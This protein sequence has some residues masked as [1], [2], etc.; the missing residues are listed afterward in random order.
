[1]RR[2]T[3]RA[4]P[5]GRAILQAMGALAVALLL[6]T[7]GPSPSAPPPPAPPAS[8]PAPQVTP[9]PVLPPYLRLAL[10]VPRDCG[11]QATRAAELLEYVV[12]GGRLD[13]AHVDVLR[14]FLAGPEALLHPELATLLLALSHD[15]DL[16]L[17]EVTTARRD[18]LLDAL[19][20]ETI[21]RSTC[22]SE[23]IS[24][25]YRRGRMLTLACLAIA[26][27]Q[28]DVA[29]WAEEPIRPF[30]L[31]NDR[32]G[33]RLPD[34]CRHFLRKELGDPEEMWSAVPPAPT[35]EAPPPGPWRPPPP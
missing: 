32:I 23:E 22:L 30:L 10:R 31:L 4:P 16:V 15:E 21:P 11:P 20:G 17:E 14:G 24:L 19:L 8:R 9:P 35:S 33:P 2:P 7:A 3:A 29:H 27:R 18:A 6:A 1:V 12:A 28:V 13:G 25:R 34:D 26:D 5:R